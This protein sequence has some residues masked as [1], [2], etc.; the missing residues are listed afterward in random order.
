MCSSMRSGCYVA[1]WSGC[2]SN[3]GLYALLCCSC[4]CSNFGSGRLGPSS[5]TPYGLKGLH[6]WPSLALCTSL[7]CEAGYGVGWVCLPMVGKGCEG[8]L[9]RRPCRTCVLACSGLLRNLAVSTAVVCFASD[10]I[11]TIKVVCHWAPRCTHGSLVCWCVCVHRQLL[12]AQDP[13]WVW[14]ASSWVCRR[15]ASADAA[16]PGGF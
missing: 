4:V 9:G 5:G 13:P 11:F 15:L 14:I 7:S 12:V 16:S 2:T 8:L 10:R 1:S 6:A 3:A